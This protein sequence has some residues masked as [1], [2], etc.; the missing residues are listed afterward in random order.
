MCGSFN[1]I[2]SNSFFNRADKIVSAKYENA[3]IFRKI[4]IPD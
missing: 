3:D 4:A 2:A 1:P